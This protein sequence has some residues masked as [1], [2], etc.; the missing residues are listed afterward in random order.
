M[1]AKPNAIAVLKQFRVI[2]KSVKSHF[3]DVESQCSISGSQLW[4]LSLVVATP[5]LKVSELAKGMAV[6]QSTASNLV[7]RLCTLGVMFKNRST[8]DQRIVHLHPTKLGIDL[9][10]KAPQPAEGILPNALS[11]LSDESLL[12]L[13]RRLEEVIQQLQPVV[14]SAEATPLADI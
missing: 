13:N 9:V 11:Q 2:F 4:A 5:G 8:S 10:A 12:E 14:K 3:S 7:D 1:P 6:H